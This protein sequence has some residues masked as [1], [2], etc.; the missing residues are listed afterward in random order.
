M[1]RCIRSRCAMNLHRIPLAIL[2]IG[3][4]GLGP[5]F[6]Q[7]P[8][9]RSGKESLRSDPLPLPGII[10]WVAENQKNPPRLAR[11]YEAGF[12][13]RLKKVGIAFQ[14]TDENLA[15]IRS[16]GGSKELCTAIKDARAP[17]AEPPKPVEYLPAAPDL[18]FQI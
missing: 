17:V 8:Q 6:C 2:L 1:S 12:I 7:Q 14:P 11:I 9:A 16:A 4:A 13:S 10:K 15:S 5:G 3:V 18:R